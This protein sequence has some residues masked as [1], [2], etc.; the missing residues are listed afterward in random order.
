MIWLRSL[1]PLPLSFGVVILGFEVAACHV[2][3][4]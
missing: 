3:L 4:N 1:V 2:G